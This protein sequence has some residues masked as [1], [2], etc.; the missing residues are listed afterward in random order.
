LI[1]E[2]GRS[3]GCDSCHRFTSQD[4]LVT[5]IRLVSTIDRL[6]LVGKIVPSSLDELS[7]LSIGCATQDFLGPCELSLG[8]VGCVLR[9]AEVKSFLELSG[10]RLF[11]PPTWDLCASVLQDVG[12][13]RSGYKINVDGN[14]VDL[15]GTTVA[16]ATRAATEDSRRLSMV[17]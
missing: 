3:Y 8:V 11:F 5:W 14:G 13:G 4:P 10:R 1:Q 2:R 16:P 7:L 6:H 15:P 12:H 17:I 9:C